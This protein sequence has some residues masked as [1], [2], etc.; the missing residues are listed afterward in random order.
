MENIQSV[1]MPKVLVKHKPYNLTSKMLP[2]TLLSP[3]AHML[4]YIVL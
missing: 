1:Y 3:K 4:G 2:T